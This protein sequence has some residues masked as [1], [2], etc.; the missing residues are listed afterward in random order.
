MELSGCCK[1][2]GAGSSVNRLVPRLRSRHPCYAFKPIVIAMMFQW[3]DPSREDLHPGP[4]RAPQTGVK[5]GVPAAAWR[6]SIPGSSA[7]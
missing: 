2:A 6:P 3:I 1:T 4:D 7:R 5:V